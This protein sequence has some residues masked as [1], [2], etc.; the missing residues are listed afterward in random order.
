[1]PYHVSWFESVTDRRFLGHLTI[2]DL[3]KCR[4]C[5]FKKRF[6]GRALSIAN[7]GPP[8]SADRDENAPAIACGR[9]RA[10]APRFGPAPIRAGRRHIRLNPGERQWRDERVNRCEDCACLPPIEV[11]PGLRSAGVC[12]C[13]SHDR[14]S[15]P[16]SAFVP[17]CGQ[18]VE[19]EIVCS[20][21]ILAFPRTPPDVRPLHDC[22]TDFLPKRAPLLENAR[23]CLRLRLGASARSRFASSPIRSIP[24]CNGLQIIS[25]RTPVHARMQV[26]A[27]QGEL[28]DFGLDWDGSPAS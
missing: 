18:T 25:S 22:P 14:C 15:V 19:A 5:H 13:R 16:Q 3:E 8:R 27:A 2:D 9:S 6:D 28:T 1:M 4:S 20:S 12:V 11:C 21:P 10:V 23:S 17:T 7:P 26:D 24:S